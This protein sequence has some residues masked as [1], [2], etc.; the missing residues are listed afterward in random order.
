MFRMITKCLI[1]NINKIFTKW[2]LVLIEHLISG[3]RDEE[4]DDNSNDKGNNNSV[5]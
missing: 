4:I 2:V 3:K 5:L 1:V